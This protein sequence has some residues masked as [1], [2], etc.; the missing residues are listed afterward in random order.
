MRRTHGADWGSR[1]RFARSERR[2][3]GVLKLKQQQQNL[4]QE[5]LQ[6][7]TTDLL[8]D[9]DVGEDALSK[10]ANSSWWNWDK[11]STLLFWRWPKGEQQIAARDGMDAYISGPL[12]NYQVR[13]RPIKT[14]VYDLLLPKVK[15]I[16]D[17]GYVKVGQGRD[18]IRS[19]IDYFIVPKADDVRPV[20]NGTSCGF[21]GSVWA[22]NFWLPTA[23]SVSRVLDYNY[24]GVDLDL[25]EMFL[26]FPLPKVFRSFSGVD[27]GQFKPDL[28]SLGWLMTIMTTIREWTK[29]TR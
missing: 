22:P 16:I 19:Y 28:G 29:R 8:R 15:K 25:G 24:C 3:R 26:N 12:P 14:A 6:D 17:R 27:L 20:Y 11:G 18:F 9:G 4:N 23:K 2:S 1:L 7:P 5:K 13:A 21:N 10:L